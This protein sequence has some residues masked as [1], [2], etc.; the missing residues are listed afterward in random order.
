M[1]ASA[2]CRRKTRDTHTKLSISMCTYV[3]RDLERH[4]KMPGYRWGGLGIG[5][6][7]GEWRWPREALTSSVSR[8]HFTPMGSNHGHQE[9]GH[10]G[11]FSSQLWVTCSQCSTD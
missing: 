2:L 3:I 1:E 11:L 9:V 5:G 10:R 6:G 8:E 4:T 7:G